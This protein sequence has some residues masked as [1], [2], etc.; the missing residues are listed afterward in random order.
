MSKK[1][2]AGLGVVAGLAVA[3][4]PVATFADDNVTSHTDAFRI[5]VP[6]VCT[7]G[8]VASGV[9][10][11]STDSTT[12]TTAADWSTTTPASGQTGN[13]DTLALSIAPGQTGS[14]TSTFTI[15][16]N[17]SGGYDFKAR[18]S[19]ANLTDAASHTIPTGTGSGANLSENGNSYWNFYVSDVSNDY[20]AAGETDENPTGQEIAS[21]YTSA[22]EVPTAATTI[23]T[24]HGA[25][26]VLNGETITVTYGFGVDAFQ[27]AGTYTGS[28]EY[29]L[30]AQ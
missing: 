15:K 4:A 23:V 5:T 20:V 13:T 25:M 6:D 1:I 14:G 12:H 3:L 29:T 8:T 10:T 11:A 19:A 7:L 28:I 24:G 30:T 22:A 26:S 16:C 21:G 27:E 2:I 9:P 17:K 18:G